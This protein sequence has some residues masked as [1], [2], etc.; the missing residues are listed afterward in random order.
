MQDQLFFTVYSNFKHKTLTIYI[1]YMFYINILSKTQN[2]ILFFAILLH[3]LI[4]FAI[5]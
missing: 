2:F 5:F 3:F 1:N 4:F